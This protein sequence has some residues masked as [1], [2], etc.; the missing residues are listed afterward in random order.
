MFPQRR[1][2]FF[3]ASITETFYYS[4]KVEMLKTVSDFNTV[5]GRIKYYRLTNNLSQEEVAAKAGLDIC[6]I[7]RYENNQRDHSLETCNKIAQAVGIKPGLLY[8]DYLNFITSDYGSKVKETRKK[9]KLT[10]QKF[11]K[12]IG[13]HRKTILRWEKEKEYP[14]REN[15]LLLAK[16]L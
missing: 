6:T 10:Q 4:Q 2:C 3:N 13:V 14:T 11:G 7:I 16:Y 12:C 15:Y 9:L 1:D 8:D 5:G